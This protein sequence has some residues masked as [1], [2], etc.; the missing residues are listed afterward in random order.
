MPILM[1]LIDVEV[2]ELNLKQVREG[3]MDPLERCL[4]GFTE[5]P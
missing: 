1:P 2:A 5:D 4:Q 3:C